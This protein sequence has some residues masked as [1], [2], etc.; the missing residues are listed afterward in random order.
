MNF[1]FP[2]PVVYFFV[3]LSGKISSTLFLNLFKGLRGYED[4]NVS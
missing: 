4:K 3:L 1:I 2:L